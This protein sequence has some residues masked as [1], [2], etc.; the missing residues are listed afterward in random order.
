[1]TAFI[2]VAYIA[3]L[4]ALA[5]ARAVPVR[6][7]IAQRFRAFFPSWRFFEDIED[8]PTLFYRR[9]REG[10]DWGPWTACISRPPRRLG[11]I[12]FNPDGNLALAY[13]SLIQQLLV[14]LPDDPRDADGVE[15][16]VPYA[17]VRALVLCTL[18]EGGA[19]A[20]THYQFRITVT[21]AGEFSAHGE[22]VLLSPI[23]TAEEP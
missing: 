9:T 14:D 10:G 3:I 20:G 16:S 18:R 6:S 13:G 19:R 4:C 8:V 23:Y 11:A 2:L 15:G 12:V 21:P 17:L 1:M 5:W 7:P 22:D